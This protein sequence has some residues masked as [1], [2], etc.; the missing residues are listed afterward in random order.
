MRTGWGWSLP[1]LA[2]QQFPALSLRL[3]KLLASALGLTAE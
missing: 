1:F 3:V 2:T